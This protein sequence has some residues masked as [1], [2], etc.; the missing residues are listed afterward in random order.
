M[1][2]AAEAET[3]SFYDKEKKAA[4]IRLRNAIQALKVLATDT[5]KGVIEKK[6][7]N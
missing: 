4:G 5:S 3:T 2:T 1:I 7:K 6:V